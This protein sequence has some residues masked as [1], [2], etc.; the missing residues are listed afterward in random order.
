MRTPTAGTVVSA[1]LTLHYDEWGGEAPLIVLV[2]GGRDHAGTWED[3]VGHLPE[4]WRLI[5]PDLRGHGRSDWAPGSAYSLWDYVAD[6]D[7][8]IRNAADGQPAVVVGH[9]LG[10]AIALAYAGIRSH[11]V[12]AAV[13][14]EPFGL[15]RGMTAETA[16]NGGISQDIVKVTPAESR[17]PAGD[18]LAAYFDHLE[19]AESRPGPV[20]RSMEEAVDRMRAVNPRVRPETIVRLA[21]RAIRP[22]PGGGFTWAFDGRVRLPAP[23]GFD[24]EDAADIWGRIQAPVLLVN[25]DPRGRDGR[26]QS[27]GF[28]EFFADCSI[29]SIPDAS[30]HV[31]LDQPAALA[32]RIQKFLLEKEVLVR[33]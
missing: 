9:S 15:G 7:A 27:D 10:G 32:G 11:R 28:E 5:A 26:V 12:R 24:K 31:Q 14:I 4:T 13:A 29:A 2:H 19:A 17:I 22:V 3:M 1:G 20:Y 18:R 6:L 33:D 21:A 16:L 25:S 8:V 23:G 30:H